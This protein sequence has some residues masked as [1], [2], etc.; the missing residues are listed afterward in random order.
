MKKIRKAVIPV[1][2][3]GTRYLP[4][5][6]AL[7][8]ELLPIVDKPVIQY[9]V[10]EAVAAGIEQ[11]I[12]VN[13]QNKVAIENYFGRDRALEAILEQRGKHKEVALIQSISNLAEFISVQQHEPLGLGHAVLQARDVV[14]DEP[15]VVF[16]GDDI[17]E[18]T[19]P[20]AKQL[21][22]T[23]MQYDGSVIGV[24]PVTRECV[25]RYGVISIAEQKEESVTRLNDI[26]EKPP[27]DTAPSLLAVGGRWL[28]TPEIFPCL[29]KTQPGAGGE[30]QLTDA[31]RT[32]LAEHPV[33][34]K[35]Y[36][37]IY[38]DCGNKTEY[39]KTMIAFALKHPDIGPAIKD[40]IQQQC[41]ST[42]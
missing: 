15:F 33:Y 7:P 4:A 9:I 29:E 1:A 38:R 21:I 14:G 10:E 16:G 31:I 8:K 27:A 18:S 2:G 30:I 12:F 13:S 34:A 6:K 26:V 28:F 19:V 37:G 36:D 24:M 20:A 42:R 41:E 11:V 32:L 23:A 5:T 3:I 35:Q 39:I 25:E 40:Y 17:V 22:D